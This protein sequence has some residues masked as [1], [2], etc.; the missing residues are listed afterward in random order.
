MTVEN[1]IFDSN[2]G[3][4]LVPFCL[5]LPNGQNLL[6]F[7]VQITRIFDKSRRPM[8]PKS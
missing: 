2:Y 5:K 3:S 1:Q 6:N 4:D 7:S 8:S